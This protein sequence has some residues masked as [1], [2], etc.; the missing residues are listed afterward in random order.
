MFTG[1]QIQEITLFSTTC[2]SH[3]LFSHQMW[4]EHYCSRGCRAVYCGRLKCLI[5]PCLSY[6]WFWHCL[7]RV[8]FSIAHWCCSSITALLLRTVSCSPSVLSWRS[9][10]PPYDRIKDGLHD[11]SNA[12]KQTW[13]P[14]TPTLRDA[15]IKCTRI[16]P[17]YNRISSVYI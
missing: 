8:N 9:S 5:S 4:R 16:A 14:Y 12:H 2:R 6:S 10:E 13:K 7:T 15:V 17:P 3:S 1:P 11:R